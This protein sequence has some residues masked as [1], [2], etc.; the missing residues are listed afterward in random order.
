VAVGG[1]QVPDGN[2]VKRKEYDLDVKD[3]FWRNNAGT[4]FPEVARTYL[5]PPMCALT[6]YARAHV[7]GCT[8]MGV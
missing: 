6:S 2:G 7:T 4:I 1:R 3:A 8:D 5:R